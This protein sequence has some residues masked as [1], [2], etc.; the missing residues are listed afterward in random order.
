M[1]RTLNEGDGFEAKADAMGSGVPAR[2]DYPHALQK[3][4]VVLGFFGLW[5][6]AYDAVNTFAANP[7]RTIHL[8]SPASVF[9]WI[10]QPWTAVIYILGGVTFP[11]VPFLYYRS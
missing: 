7:A 1:G 9:P 10:I 5:L 11:L 8:T 4:V 2:A 3:W 6:W